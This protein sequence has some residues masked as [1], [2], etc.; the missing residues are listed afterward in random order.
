VPAIALNEVRA[1]A[2]SALAPSSDD[3]ADV[4]F[5]YPDS[6]TPPALVLTWDEP[7]LEPET[8]GPCLFTA[9]F[10]VLCCV[11]R[12][13]P[14][15]GPLEELI[16]FVIGRMAADDYPWPVAS[17]QAPRWLEFG[18]V[19]LLGARVVYRLMVTTNGGS[20]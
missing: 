14:A 10:A 20:Q 7:W 17:A 9:R 15:I 13:E 6:V 18:G 4:L 3:D 16:G 5:D 11:A 19:K 12:I 8:M 2:A 1:R